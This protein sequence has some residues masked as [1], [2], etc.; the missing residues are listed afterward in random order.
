MRNIARLTAA[1]ALTASALSAHAFP[2]DLGTL[3]ATPTP[4]Y[5]LLGVGL[6]GFNLLGPGP[7]TF[8]LSSRSNVYIDLYSTVNV[9][10]LGSFDLYN[11]TGNLLQSQQLSQATNLGSVVGADVL[12]LVNAGV[13]S[14]TRLTFGNL[15]AGNDY[16]FTFNPGLLSVGLLST[17]TF[18]AINVNA[19]AVPEASA[20]AL[21]G[22]GLVGIAAVT[23]LRRPGA[24]VPRAAG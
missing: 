12:G 19:P 4:G 17:A 15:Q 2:T 20:M 23:R 10:L 24:L 7:F 8:D 22:L 3:S 18:T 13:L 16:R 1:A 11:A 14:H 6:L 21:M 9:S 5:S